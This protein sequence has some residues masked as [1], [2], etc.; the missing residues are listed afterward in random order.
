VV[1]EYPG[2]S[3]PVTLE[4]RP[5]E[6]S[7]LES[8]KSF[9][10]AEYYGP[11]ERRPRQFTVAAEDFDALAPDCD[12]QGLLERVLIETAAERSRGAGG[13]RQPSC[14]GRR[15]GRKNYATLEH[16]GSPHRGRITEAEKEL[17]RNNLEQ[18]NR[19]L[20]DTGEREIDPNDPTMRERYG[21]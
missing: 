21:L 16:A 6:V 5:E 15:G 20:H 7:R 11:G 18:I 1:L 19:R 9:V 4:V 17:V 12:M 8:A 3:G 2:V 14:G 13:G 10:R